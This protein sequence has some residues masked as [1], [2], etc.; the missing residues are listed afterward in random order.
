MWLDVLLFF[1]TRASDSAVGCRR[2]KAVNRL[3]SSHIS[4]VLY[5]DVANR[6]PEGWKGGKLRIS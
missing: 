3:P 2:K 1:S 4:R 5:S 6:R